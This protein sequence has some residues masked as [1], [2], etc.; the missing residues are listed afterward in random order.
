MN[1]RSSGYTTENPDFPLTAVG[2]YGLSASPYGT[3]DQGGNAY[4]W[5]ET[6]MYLTDRCLRGGSWAHDSAYLSTLRLS[7]T[8][9][10]EYRTTGFRVASSALTA[11]PEP[12]TYAMAA[13]GLVAL[14]FYGRRRRQ[15]AARL[16][17]EDP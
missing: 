17:S 3:F 13:M 2:D 7:V 1:Y 11:V 5:N 4:E 6:Q 8:P 10:G 9:S 16:R 14:G 15:V 12:S